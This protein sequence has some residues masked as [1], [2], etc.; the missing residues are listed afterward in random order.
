[1]ETFRKFIQS[2]RS[3]TWVLL[4]ALMAVSLF[5]LH[6]HLH[7]EETVADTSAYM[8]DGH[9]HKSSIHPVMNTDGHDNH[10]D[11]SVLPVVSDS[12]LKNVT[13]MPLLFVA[14]IVITFL[15]VTKTAH[16]MRPRLMNMNIRQFDRV[17]PQLRAPPAL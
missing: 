9:S 17:T 3:V 11:V 1:M 8:H 15:S 6:L 12:I 4:M 5:P 7:D 14:F 2:H 16:V 13:F 10:E